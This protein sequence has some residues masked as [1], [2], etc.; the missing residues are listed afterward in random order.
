MYSIHTPTSSGTAVG[1]ITAVPGGYI[2]AV[3]GGANKATY[4]DSSAMI[5]HSIA[6]VLDAMVKFFESWIGASVPVP[7]LD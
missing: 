1:A 4:G 7:H 6:S 2:T 5:F 3:F